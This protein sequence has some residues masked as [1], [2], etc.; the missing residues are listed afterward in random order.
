ML[1]KTVC[2]YNKDGYL[3]YAENFPGAFVRGRTLKGALEKFPREMESYLLW[4]NGTETPDLR[5]EIEPVLEKESG[6][7]IKDA[8]SDVIFP[9]E[10]EPLTKEEYTKLKI[11][12]LRSAMDFERLYDSV[13]NKKSA[14]RSGKGDLLRK[15][16]LHR[17]GNVPP[18]NEREQLLFRRDRR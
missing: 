13:P 16:S 17:R 3:V 7:N 1:L 9:G 5:L 15:N 11:L 14:P 6:L 18:H 4:A 8:D 2:E 12:A 10:R